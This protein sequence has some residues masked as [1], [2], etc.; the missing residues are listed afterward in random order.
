MK[1]RMFQILDELNLLDEQGGS[2]NV[3]VYNQVVSVNQYT[4]HGHVTIGV[5]PQTAQE[6]ALNTKN[7]RAILIIVD[8]DAYNKIDTE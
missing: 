1:K 8:M 2:E 5:S 3:G 6:L 4:N 7:K